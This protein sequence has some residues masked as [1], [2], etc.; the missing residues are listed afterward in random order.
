[1]F[2]N[3]IAIILAAFLLAGCL[4][5]RGQQGVAAGGAAGALVGQAIG[6]NTEATLLGAA[7]GGVLGYIVGNEMDK[8]DRNRL[9][10]AYE[11]TRTGYTSEWRNPDNGR[12]YTVTPTRSYRDYNANL[13]CRDAE[14]TA[15]IDGRPQTTHSTACR[16]NGV[17]VLR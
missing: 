11:N 13:D 4:Q 15:I 17:W 5:T 10:D 3:I 12:A 8:N 9:N 7:V 16:E 14:I 2:K 6:H 1:M